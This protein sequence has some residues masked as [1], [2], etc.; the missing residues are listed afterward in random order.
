MRPLKKIGF[1][2]AFIM[3]TLV[4]VGFYGGGFWNFL[5][6]VFD[7]ILI[8][9]IDHFVGLDTSNIPSEQKAEVNKE[10]YYRFVTYVWVFVQLAF[11]GWAVVIISIGG[12]QTIIEWTGFTLGFALVTGGIGITVAHELGHRT[13]RLEQFYSQVLLMTVCYMHFFIEHNRGH[14]VNVATPLDPATAKRGQNFYAFWLQ[15]VLGSWRHAWDIEQSSLAR[16]SLRQWGLNN[17]MIG[18]VIYP[19]LFCGILTVATYSLA[20]RFVWEFPI[21]FFMQSFLAFSI[22]ELVNYV[23]HY[24]ISRR[25]LAPNQYE[26]V[27]P[28]HSWNAS[29][30]IS[31]FFLFQLQRHSDHHFHASKRYQTLDHHDHSPQLPYAYPTMIILALIPPLWFKLMDDRLCLWESNFQSRPIP[32]PNS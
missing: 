19:L 16:R 28:I 8:P 2:S 3:P 10:S 22:L 21:F 4:V 15:T 1:L 32:I 31:N 29:H 24:G 20:G 25:E 13:S 27:N 17:R 7:F 9:L 14:H 12:P 18:Y 6:I 23:E 5:I 11:F 30:L 26:P